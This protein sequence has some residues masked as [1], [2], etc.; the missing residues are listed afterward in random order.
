M[1]VQPVTTV[2]LLL[3]LSLLSAVSVAGQ[4]NATIDKNG[5]IKWP[6]L[7]AGKP[8][9]T[10]G[11][12]VSS[13]GLDTFYD[14]SRSVIASSLPETPPLDT[15][16]G[17]IDGKLSIGNELQNL[18]KS[19]VGFAVCLAIGLLF[20]IIFPLVGLC[21][22]CCRCCGNCGGKMLQREHPKATCRKRAFM[23]ILLVLIVF[24]G[25]GIICTY[26]SN[27][28]L[29]GT[30]S[31]MQKITNNAVSDILNFIDNVDQ[32][33]KQILIN[34]VNFVKKLLKAD[35]DEKR[36]SS[37][38]TKP[39][40]RNL[41]RDINF[42]GILTN[43]KK[44]VDNAMRIVSDMDTSLRTLKS[45]TATIAGIPSQLKNVETAVKS[46]KSKLN[47]KLN[48][49]T[50][51]ML[52]NEIQKG[53]TNAVKN[54]NVQA[55]VDEMTKK[56]IDKIQEDIRKAIRK[57]KSRIEDLDIETTVADNVKLISQYDKY[58]NYGGI[59]IASILL[60]VV[61]LQGFG[62]MCGLFCS[63][64]NVNQTERGC[65]S[66]AGGNMLMASVGFLFIFGGIIMLVTTVLYLAGSIAERYMCQSIKNPSRIDKYVNTFIDTD[67]GNIEFDIQGKTLKFSVSGVLRSCKEG[68]TLYDAVQ[69]GNV[70]DRRDMLNKVKFYKDKMIPSDF[71]KHLNLK[72]LNLTDKVGKLKRQIT[73]TEGSSKQLDDVRKKLQ[74][75]RL[76]LTKQHPEGIT[77][78]KGL[79]DL[80][81]KLT[82]LD[83][84][85]PKKAGKYIKASVDLFTRHIFEIFESFINDTMH[86]LHTD[87]GNCRPIWSVYNVLALETVC[88]GIVDP[89]NGFWLALGWTIF[90]GLPSLVFSVK[91]AKHLRRMK[92]VDEFTTTRPGER[93]MSVNSSKQQSRTSRFTRQHLTLIAGTRDAQGVIC[94]IRETIRTNDLTHL[95][96]SKTD[97]SV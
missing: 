9:V 36:I 1:G 2:Q 91:L 97:T 86:H 84:D 78:V 66:N 79:N 70:I 4:N 72:N 20:F 59:S 63:N 69:L 31:S 26:V 57:V 82:K 44:D 34:N 16:K 93:S 28:H 75:L 80:T 90:F 15:V 53:V 51:N 35:T 55:Q 67:H 32:Q 5:T 7:P 30:L 48:N 68:K 81:A 76:L 49:G 89:L 33:F 39:L 10:E 17:I 56:H 6:H 37:L 61:L 65:M 92:Y 27:N 38:I 45:E 54:M 74:T 95:T 50:Q 85:L 87:L 62:L 58:R 14:L 83:T 23:G 21:F 13:G 24:Q 40:V 47:V 73:S 41:S 77:N 8:Y 64:S 46:L 29:S 3:L 19:S 94:Y 42:D 96:P 18:V 43:I 12:T 60:L 52:K 88:H 22:C 71:D 11:T 25:A